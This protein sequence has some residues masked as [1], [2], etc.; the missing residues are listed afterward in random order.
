MNLFLVK[1]G[2]YQESGYGNGEQGMDLRDTKMKQKNMDITTL[3][4]VNKHFSIWLPLPRLNM[5]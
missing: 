1:F 4:Q 2:Q 3:I 5:R